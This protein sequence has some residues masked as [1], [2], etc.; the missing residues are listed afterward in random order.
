MNITSSNN[1][2][3]VPIISHQRYYLYLSNALWEKQ[4]L[5]VFLLGNVDP[6]IP[7]GMAF[8][9]LMTLHFPTSIYLWIYTTLGIPNEFWNYIWLLEL[10]VFW[11]YICV[12][13]LHTWL[14][15]FHLFVFTIISWY[16]I[17][18]TSSYGED[19]KSHCHWSLGLIL[20]DDMDL[21]W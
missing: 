11:T 6:F 21:L 3:L 13:F 18:F 9:I 8:Y 20:T 12:S 14:L 10:H 1:W 19:T 4:R 2:A 16:I 17:T 5:K 15:E 7:R